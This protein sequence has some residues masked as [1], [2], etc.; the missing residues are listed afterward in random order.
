[1]GSSTYSSPVVAGGYMYIGCDDHKVY[2]LNAATGASVWNYTTGLWVQTA[3]AIADGR[4]YVGSY[5]TK[6]HCV[7]ANNGTSIWNYTTSGQVFSSP[8]VAGGRVYVGSNDHKLYCLYANNGTKIWIY[9]AGSA[10]PSAPAIVNGRVF[11]GSDDYKL[12]CVNATTG[13]GIWNYTTGSYIE[14]SPTVADGRVYV[15]SYDNKVHCVYANNGT[16]IWNYTT[17]NSVYSSP[18]VAGGRVY[19][20]SVDKKIYCLNATSGVKLWN[21]T[22]GNDVYS[23]PAVAGDRVYVGSYDKNVYCLNATSGTKI[24]NYSTGAGLS[25]SPA[26]AGGH[27]YIGTV[28]NQLLCLPMILTFTNIAPSISHPDNITYSFG[29][30]GAQIS[31]TITDSTTSTTGY[32]IYRNGTSQVSYPWTTGTPVVRNVTGLPVGSYN[33]TIVAT[34]GFGGSAQDMVI[35]TVLNV[36]PAITF[37]SDITY[38]AGAAGNSISWTVTDASTATTGYTIY[39]NG[40]SVAT[41]SW[42][43]GTPVV[44]N[45]D[46]LSVGSYNFTIVTTDGLGGSVQDTVIVTVASQSS[47]DQSMPFD[48]FTFSI[49]MSL[50]VALLV[51]WFLK[52]RA[53]KH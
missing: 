29:A 21:Y 13:K 49:F 14:C 1:L 5:D 34:D 33:F 9:T 20:G 7:Y 16:S 24:W 10:L 32:T 36:A 8:A 46:G 28:T 12:H 52:K 50:S 45:V 23:S 42:T 11:I 47:P 37:Q 3:L 35:V 44:Q 26:V 41:G 39:R 51:A 53:I 27:V 38:S 2:C 40:T 43:S 17:G 19:V 18:A 4:A 30:P 31:W 48:G 6:V 22:T 25:S 15:G